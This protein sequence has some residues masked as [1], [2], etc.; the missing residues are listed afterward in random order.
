M[1]APLGRRGFLRA[2]AA[3]PVAA[4]TLAR[5]ALDGA[6]N[7]VTPSAARLAGLGVSVVPEVPLTADLLIRHPKLL[8]LYKLGS[9]PEWARKQMVREAGW[10]VGHGAISPDVVALR[11]VSLSA[12]VLIH[13]R[14]FEKKF[15]KRVDA[16]LAIEMARRAFMETQVP[17][18]YD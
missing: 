7:M 10:R 8:T 15:W 9:L 3:A 4:R 5:S 6:A 14:R 17:P 1:N 11:S 2:L 16:D 12:K 18:R 13:E